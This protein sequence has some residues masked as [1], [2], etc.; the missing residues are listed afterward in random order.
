MVD[1]T[2]SGNIGNKALKRTMINQNLIVQLKNELD[3]SVAE[4]NNQRIAELSQSL[5]EMYKRNFD[6]KEAELYL[7][8]SLNAYERLYDS[9]DPNLVTILNQISALYFEMGMPALAEP[10]CKKLTSIYAKI[11][12]PEHPEVAIGLTNLALIAQSKNQYEKANQMLKGALLIREKALGK[13]NLEVAKSLINLSN[14]ELMIKDYASALG[15]SRQAVAV[16]EDILDDKDLELIYFYEQ[17]VDILLIN[18]EFDNACTYA[19]KILSIKEIKLGPTR[20]EICPTLMTLAKIYSSQTKYDLAIKSIKRALTMKERVYGVNHIQL[21]PYFI[22]LAGILSLQQ[23]Y[24][25]SEEL[26]KQSLQIVERGDLE[27]NKPLLDEILFKFA[28]LYHTQ[29]RYNKSK[30]FWLRLL[31][32][33]Q[34]FEHA[35]IDEL[36][37]VKAKLLQCSYYQDESTESKRYLDELLKTKNNV[38]VVS[39]VK[40]AQILFEVANDL[41]KKEDFKQAEPILQKA[42]DLRTKYL[43][44]NHVELVDPLKSMSVILLKTF[45]ESEAEH[46]L[47][48]AQKILDDAN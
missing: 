32:L 31:E 19:N 9:E 17:L 36:C 8:K 44:A 25:Q 2:T 5:A 18:N 43:G 14:L 24:S 47:A 22:E 38:M 30:I 40:V 37:L 16:V 34:K 13:N 21:V 12:G 33:R 46:I 28:N 7:K 42:I 35:N 4:Q 45:R 41:I 6:F 48:C 23:N 11:H 15:Y 1:Y 27:A 29:K 26:L 20:Q 3:N 39:G 10:Y